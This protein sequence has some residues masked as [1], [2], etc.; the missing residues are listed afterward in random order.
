MFIKMLDIAKSI[1][2]RPKTMI[3][4]IAGNTT[5][6]ETTPTDYESGKIGHVMKS[7]NLFYVESN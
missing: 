4:E 6:R 2:T 1:N 5:A 7:E 3:I